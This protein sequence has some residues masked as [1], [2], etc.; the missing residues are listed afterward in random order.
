MIETKYEVYISSDPA[1]AGLKL[2]IV[3]RGG[4]HQ[5]VAMPMQLTMKEFAEDETP[6][7]T[8]TLNRWLADD[9]LSAMAEALD[10]R[11]VKV[12]NEHKVHGQLEATKYHLEDLRTLLK[13][14]TKGQ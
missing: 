8:L 14:N 9:F 4:G 10:K 1:F 11:G 5:R 6:E 12:E 3:D 2:W 7:P 13:I